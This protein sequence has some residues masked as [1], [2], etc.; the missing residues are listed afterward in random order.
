MWNYDLSLAIVILNN[1]LPKE[2]VIPARRMME[3]E[4]LKRTKQ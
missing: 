1:S 3:L 4:V 2:I